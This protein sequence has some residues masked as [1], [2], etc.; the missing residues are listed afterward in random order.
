MGKLLSSSDH[1]NICLNATSQKVFTQVQLLFHGP[2]QAR[3]SPE[4]GYVGNSLFP[5]NAV[6]SLK[7]T[8]GALPMVTPTGGGGTARREEVTAED[9]FSIPIESIS[10]ALKS[11]LR[12]LIS[13]SVQEIPGNVAA[14]CSS[15]IVHA[16]K[17]LWPST[18]LSQICKTSSASR[19]T[20]IHEQQ[21]SWRLAERLD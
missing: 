12:C 1:P 6:I 11:G 4:M 8:G 3:L 17:E 14:K 13:T 18:D 15:D 5:T 7:V 20:L 2:A 21:G 19:E 16:Q 10:S 9:S